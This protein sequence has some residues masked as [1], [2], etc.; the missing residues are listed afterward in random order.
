[1][2]KITFRGLINRLLKN[3]HI[4]VISILLASVVYVMGYYIINT[5]RVVQIPA[6][7]VLPEGYVPYSNV[8]SHVGVII[9]ANNNIKDLIDPSLIEAVIDFS[10]VKTEGVHI[11]PVKV[12]YNTGIVKKG[13]I[14]IAPKPLTVRVGFSKEN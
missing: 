14:D 10:F 9:Y 13:V 4:K 2:N 7:V 6:R 5:P 12:T 1:M 3:W 8:P 11:A